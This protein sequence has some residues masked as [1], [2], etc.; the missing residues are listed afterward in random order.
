MRTSI[1]L[2]LAMALFLGFAAAS[3]GE[4]LYGFAVG[5]YR[6]SEE[7]PGEDYGRVQNGTNINL[8]FHYFPDGSFFGF[9]ARTYFGILGSGYGWKG[10]QEMQTIDSRK[11]SDLRISVGPS[12]KIKLGHMVTIPLALGPVFSFYWEEGDN[13]WLPDGTY[14]YKRSYYE[15]LNLG[16]MGDVSI[17][18]APFRSLD[19]LF[20]K[21]GFYFG[22]DFLRFEKGEMMME[23]RHSYSTRYKDPEYSAFAFAV[24]FGLGV[25]LD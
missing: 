7:F 15:A 2:A 6:L 9:I 4:A 3:Y 12:F 17:V 23:Y 5:Y 21:Q 19:W 18:I 11:A 10:D 8:T 20:F 24:Y 22:W 14:E 16:I 1:K 13:S 25:H